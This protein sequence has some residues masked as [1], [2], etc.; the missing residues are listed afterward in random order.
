MKIKFE[1]VGEIKCKQRPRISTING[2]ARAITPKETVMYENY[3]KTEYQRQA[4]QHYFGYQPLS[5][6][7]VAYFEP[8]QELKEQMEY[9]S[10][11]DNVEN[12][13]V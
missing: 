7:V 5:I 9:L 3:I 4:K 1:V 6:K 10:Q 12:T 8:P 2:Y 11:F 13:F